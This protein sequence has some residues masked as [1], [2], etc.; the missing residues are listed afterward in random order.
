MFFFSNPPVHLV[1][2][3]FG[4]AKPGETGQGSWQPY[5]S[6]PWAGLDENICAAG[7]G[8]EP[9]VYDNFNIV[10][11]SSENLRK[12]LGQPKDLDALKRAKVMGA[13]NVRLILLQSFERGF[14]LRDSDGAT[15][16]LA[17]IFLNNGAYVREGY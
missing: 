13:E 1:F 3:K 12:Q 14:I 6:K 5:P 15:R 2:V 7:D 4:V 16:R 17:Y 8:L 9:P 10:W 11:C